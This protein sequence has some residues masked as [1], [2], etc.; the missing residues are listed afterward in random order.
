[1][2][3]NLTTP[4]GGLN[5]KSGSLY[6]GPSFNQFQTRLKNSALKIEM[7]KADTG[8]AG[9][10]AAGDAKGGLAKNFAASLLANLVAA[11]KLAEERNR[12]SDEE[13]ATLVRAV[14]DF[15]DET[16]SLFGEAEANRLMANLILATD[17]AVT[18]SRV[19]VAVT[20][21]LGKIK[22]EAMGAYS[23]AGAAQETLDKASDKLDKISEAVAFLNDGP[24]GYETVSVARALNDYFGEERAL[25]EDKKLFTQDLKWISAAEAAGSAAAGELVILKSELGDAAVTAA[26]DYLANELAAEEAARI[27]TELKE[28]EDVLDA[29]DRVREKLAAMDKAAAAAAGESAA[30]ASIAV[31]AAAAA[32]DEAQETKAGYT[33]SEAVARAAIQGAVKGSA[34][35]ASKSATFDEY[36]QKTMTM[37]INRAVKE[38]QKLAD[39]LLGL[40]SL[41]LG[42]D[43]L[44][45]SS[46]VTLGGWPGLGIVHSTG[47]SVSVGYKRE[48]SV[49]I[50]SDG[51][52]EAG[53]SESVEFSASF[54]SV[55]AVGIG[56]G[57]GTALAAAA[58]LDL[59]KSLEHSY[60]NGRI[61]T[62]RASSLTTKSFLLSKHV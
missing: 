11:D 41:K 2:M 45:S 36:L 27:L 9:S 16:K 30:A 38:E 53:M 14:T 52:I 48:F 15:V 49:S 44:T 13:N 57:F 6:G 22:G 29:V 51:K 62:N 42:V 35:A 33:V 12:H 10:K 3:L 21:F 17:G 56:V 23:M 50:G 1:M 24:S 58:T 7:P 40:A 32:A 59:A 8:A 39:R 5:I 20:E 55:T 25:E 4:V 34:E 61:G 54:T 19:A 26:A 31:G 28:D 46:S 37:E 18:E 60:S 47:F 43:L